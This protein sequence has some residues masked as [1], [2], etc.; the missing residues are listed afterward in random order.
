MT[1]SSNPGRTKRLTDM[2]LTSWKYRHH[3][4]I[5]HVDVYSGWAFI[6]AEWATW[7]FRRLSKPVILTLHGGNLPNFAQRWPKRVSRL[8]GNA[9]VVTAPS[10]Y[11]AEQL[12]WLRG[13]IRLLPN[14]IALNNYSFRLRSEPNPKLLWLR[15]FHEIYNPRQAIRVVDSL[16]SEF[17]EIFL[18]MVGP[19]KGDGSLQ[20]TQKLANDL[21]LQ[22]SVHFPGGVPK[23]SVPEW[24]SKGDIF[25]N[26]TNYDNTPVSVIEAMA[27]GLPII[28]TNVGG[29]PYSLEHEKDALLVPPNNTGAMSS[30]VKRLLKEPGLSGF[31]SRNARLKIVE[32]Y[33]WRVVL[34]QWKRLYWEVFLHA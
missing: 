10:K 9:M 18:M 11:L 2:L 29:I 6:W 7:L 3:Y 4:D 21:E 34:P 14:P 19:D 17:P 27:S 5:A 8:L 20:K 12:K 32:K 22:Q 23:S 15:A 16:K 33:D 31:L 26:T 1:T 30:A 24:M 25:I 28:S 13:D